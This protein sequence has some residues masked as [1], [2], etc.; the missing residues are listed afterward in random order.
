MLERG[1]KKIL[2]DEFMCCVITKLNSGLEPNT[3]D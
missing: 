3:P 2:I 1:V